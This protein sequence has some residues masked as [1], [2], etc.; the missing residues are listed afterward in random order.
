MAREDELFKLLD[1]VGREGPATPEEPPAPPEVKPKAQLAPISKTNF[2]I[3]HDTHPVVF[4]VVLLNKYGIDWIEWEPDTLWKEIS[5]D[6]RISAI[7]DHAKAKIQACRTLHI[8]E[9][10]WDQW[11][12][13]CWITQA[14]NNNIPDFQVI[15]K[16][17]IPQLMVSVDTASVVRKG[18]EFG[19]Q[20]QSFVAAT[21]VDRG[22]V[23]APPPVAFCQDEIVQ[24]LEVEN[25]DVALELVPEVKKGWQ[26]L[27]GGADVELEETPLGVQL[28]RLMVAEEYRR[29]RLRQLKKQ[30]ELLI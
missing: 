25:K 23:Y 20:V 26:E 6:F 30:L 28:A 10:Y 27:S 12:V 1:G 24:L 16:P 15:Q 17:T 13:F 3:H 18:E 8:N 2:F 5:E 7:S 11:E 22:V 21:M 14:L 29:L 19:Q 4:D 9:W